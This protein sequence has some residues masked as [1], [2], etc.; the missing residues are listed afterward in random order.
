MFLN[1]AN[2]SSMLDSN[3]QIKVSDV[4]HKAFIEIN[5]D[6][7]KAAAATGKLCNSFSLTRVFFDTSAVFH[8]SC[9][10]FVRILLQFLSI[11]IITNGILNRFS[12]DVV[13]HDV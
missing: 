13:Q 7:V 2:F 9:A 3:E 11:I 4:V 10:S 12:C 6:G 8:I 1:S 5:E